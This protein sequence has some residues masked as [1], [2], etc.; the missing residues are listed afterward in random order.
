MGQQIRTSVQEIRKKSKKSFTNITRKVQGEFGDETLT[1][2]LY[3][4]V[5]PR[6]SGIGI[7][8][9]TLH[10]DDSTILYI[11]TGFNFIRCNRDKKILKEL[12]TKSLLLMLSFHLLHGN[13]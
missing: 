5:I 9:V 10:P 11:P 4:F 3:R 8:S 7:E 2:T 13:R 1:L 6:K 12:V